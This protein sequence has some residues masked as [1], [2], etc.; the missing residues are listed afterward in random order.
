MS[1]GRAPARL[2]IPRDARTAGA[3]GSAEVTTLEQPEEREGFAETPT[4]SS[5]RSRGPRCRRAPSEDSRCVSP[6]EPP[7]PPSG[8]QGGASSRAEVSRGTAQTLGSG[9]LAALGQLRC[10]SCLSPTVT[11]CCPHTR[12]GWSRSFHRGQGRAIPLVP[13]GERRVT[14]QQDTGAVG[15][16]LGWL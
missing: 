16:A 5:V 6:G 9:L 14:P 13:G 4:G 2:Q 8:T 15:G 7:S 11:H 1:W 10:L 3:P 12:V